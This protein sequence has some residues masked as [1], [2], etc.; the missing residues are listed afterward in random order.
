MKIA[1]SYNADTPTPSLFGLIPQE[2]VSIA[3]SYLGV[4]SLFNYYHTSH[5]SASSVSYDDIFKLERFQLIIKKN[6]E[7]SNVTLVMHAASAGRIVL[8]SK[9]R[10]LRLMNAKKCEKCAVVMAKVS[11]AWGTFMC[12]GCLA[13]HDTSCGWMPYHDR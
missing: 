9:A 7:S 12:R 13:Q 6:F 2:I 11:A 3:V 4:K 8:P 1:Y 5:A 10:L